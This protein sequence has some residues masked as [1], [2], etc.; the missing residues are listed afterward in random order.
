VWPAG[1]R[2]GQQHA[3]EQRERDLP[4]EHQQA[5][6]QVVG[7][8]PADER[9]QQQRCKL[10][11]SEQADQQWIVGEH[12]H[13]VRDRHISNERSES[14]HSRSREDQ[15]EIP[16]VRSGVRSSVKRRRTR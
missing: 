6:V 10:A 12:R 11:D 16:E 1:Q 14:G 13:L 3:G 15:P 7:Q 8:R 5:A 2:V 9:H 4:T